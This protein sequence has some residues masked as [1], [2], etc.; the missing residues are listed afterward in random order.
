MRSWY[1]RADLGQ[2]GFARARA[3]RAPPAPRRPAPWRRSPALSELAPR[4]RRLVACLGRFAPADAGARVPRRRSPPAAGRRS[5]RRPPPTRTAPAGARP[6]SRRPRI[7]SHPTSCGSDTACCGRS[8]PTSASA[9]TRYT[10]PPGRP[11]HLEFLARRAQARHDGHERLHGAFGRRVPPLRLG[12]RPGR[13]EERVRTVPGAHLGQV[14]VDLLG[15][16]G[17]DWD[18]GVP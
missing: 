11:R 16:E 7:S 12:L 17:H 2:H 6:R 5:P 4:L 1:C 14:P 3:V 18:A 10:A 15:D 13:L 9:V 8:R